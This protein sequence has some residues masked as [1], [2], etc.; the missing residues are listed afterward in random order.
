ML[1]GPWDELQDHGT[2]VFHAGTEVQIDHQRTPWPRRLFEAGF[3]A[4]LITLLWWMDTV[5]QFKVFGTREGFDAFRLV[6]HQVTSATV[7]FLLVP[8]VAWWLSVFPLQR[9]RVWQALI[10]HAVGTVLFAALHYFGMVLLRWAVYSVFGRQFI[11]SDYW[12][13]NL[14]FE[15]QKDLKI[16]LGTVAIIAGYRYYRRHEASAVQTRPDRLIVQTGSG[17]AV[18]R[19]DDI[20]YL[21]AA[22]NYVV[23]G[24]GEKEYLVRETLSRLEQTLAPEQIVRTHRSY[25]VNVDRISE[26]RARDSGG[27]E[28][29]MNSGKRVPLSRGYR[30]Q[31]K[32]HITG[33]ESRSREG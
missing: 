3:F 25:L 31:F 9:D 5:T 22:R 27:H 19:Q 11:F 16:Y 21:E 30:E 26:I 33:G 14:V 29:R 24:T 32:S 23:V 15:Y 1:T 13:A 2:G 10:G 17:E 4:A 20:E 18:V 6:V 8:A 28:I 7:V 12:F